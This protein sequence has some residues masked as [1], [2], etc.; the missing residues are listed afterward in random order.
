MIAC[1]GA[2]R[3]LIADEPNFIGRMPECHTLACAVRWWRQL[4]ES[5]VLPLRLTA[6]SAPPGWPSRL[7]PV[8]ALPPSPVILDSRSMEPRVAT[9][10]LRGLVLGISE[11]LPCP[12][13]NRP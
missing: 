9:P 10:R 7:L 12:L 2:S 6:E 3:P 4:H 11:L 5:L 8:K 13:L 1:D